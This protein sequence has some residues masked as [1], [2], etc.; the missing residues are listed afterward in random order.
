M[1][2]ELTNMSE[3]IHL[4]MDDI[5]TPRGGCTTHFASYIVEYLSE[6]GAKWLD[7]PN[8]IRLNPNIPFRTR[9]NGA[10][11]LQFQLDGYSA[12]DILEEIEGKVSTYIHE[13]YPNTNPGLVCFKGAIHPKVKWLSDQALWRVIPI[14]LATRLITELEISTYSQG[15]KRGL[16]GALAAI[17]NQLNDDYTYE[18]IAYRDGKAT[19][20]SRNVDLESVIEMERSL[21]DKLFSSLDNH[22]G[23]LLIEPHG[24]DPVL[25]GI[26]GE[27][28]KSVSSASKFIRCGQEIDR[29]MI[30]RTNQGTAQHLQNVIDINKI[31]PYMSLQVTGRVSNE[32]QMHE[33]GHVFFNINDATG[34]IACAVYEPTGPFRE[35]AM[36]LIPGDIVTVFAGVRPA[37]ST[38]GM[39]LNIE[40]LEIVETATEMKPTNPICPVCLKRMKSAGKNKGFKCVKCGYR[41]REGKKIETII[42]REVSSGVYLPPLS[43][44]RHLTRP[45]SRL[46]R[47]NTSVP[48]EMI[49]DWHSP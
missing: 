40:G 30:F 38:H 45:H 6:K 21:G 44:Q 4:G 24:N 9:G 5:D 29:W 47:N 46:N 23:R 42:D 48:V 13:D 34:K 18:F 36:R 27:D 11:S 15:N 14:K 22:D 17:G 31:R 39:T 35:H 7:Y 25:F 49:K 10:V 3:I 26:R 43:A 41:D 1:S 16:I 19:H 2:N 32:P 8:L 20:E 33:G 28:S 12:G 37:S